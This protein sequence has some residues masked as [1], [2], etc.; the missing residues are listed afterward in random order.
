MK[1]QSLIAGTGCLLLCSAAMAT[2]GNLS[3]A[4]KQFMMTAAKTNMIEAHEG[5]VSK[6]QATRD[7]IK[8]LAK[9]LDQDHTKAYEELSVLASKLGVDIPKG[10]DIAK[11]SSFERMVHLKGA[12]FDQAYA[13]EE[14]AA[15][16]QALALFK[17]EA[18]HGQDSDVRAYASKMIPVL[19]DHL[20]KAEQC[21]KPMK[22]S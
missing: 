2:A 15:H 17:R 21:A 13:S 14:V 1:F 3:S 6:D 18:E 4:D 22:H 11:N 19:E 8:S 12:R 10:I 7:D 5:Q 20:H 16:R 9:T